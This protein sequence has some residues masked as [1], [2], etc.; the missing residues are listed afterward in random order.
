M[1]SWRK[2]VLYIIVAIGTSSVIVLLYIYRGK[3]GRI[4][5]PFFM[6]LIIA[7]LVY[8]LVNR[9]EQFK[10]SR[11]AGILLIYLCITLLTA[12]FIVFIFPE[13]VNNAKELAVTLP[14]IALKYQNIINGFLTYIQ[15]SNW[16]PDIKNAV[17]REIQNGTAAAQSIIMDNLK[18]SLMILFDTIT[19]LFD[20]VLAMII[21]YYFI[22]DGALLR[23][24]VLSFIPRKWRNGI[25]GAGREINR[26]LSNFIQG[27]LLTA[28]IIGIM[29]MIGLSIV[30][31]KYPLVLGMIGGIANIIPYFG[32]VIGAVPAVAVALIQSP[33]KAMW[34]ILVFAIV[35]QIDNAF[36]SSKIIEGRVGLHPLTTILVVLIGGEFFGI[37]GMLVAV[38]VAAI[39]KVIFKRA[40]ESIV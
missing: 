37:I 18:K 35:Q 27:Q 16:P 38:P 20:L 19:T 14:D 15:S 30:K 22:K 23:S 2:L 29:E 34:T 10:I 39:L 25:A 13:M 7:Y 24:A 21:A 31:V 28:I 1:S 4:I 26:I 36:I 17:F 9:L 11:R 12:A 3:V 6:A 32:P 40:I 5:S 8:P 33:L